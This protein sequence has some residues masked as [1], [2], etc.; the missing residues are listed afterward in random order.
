MVGYVNLRSFGNIITTPYVEVH[1]KAL[2][3]HDGVDHRIIDRSFCEI[4]VEPRLDRSPF[5]CLQVPDDKQGQ[6]SEQ[7]IGGASKRQEDFVWMRFRKDCTP[8]ASV[9][10]KVNE[11]GFDIACVGRYLLS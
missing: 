10:S 11:A 2:V 9:P 7:P 8:I 6:R 5:W 4:H 3:R 1:E